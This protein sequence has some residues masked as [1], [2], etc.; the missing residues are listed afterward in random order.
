[1]SDEFSRTQWATL[2]E[3]DWSIIATYHLKMSTNGFHDYP[4]KLMDFT[5]ISQQSSS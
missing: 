3:R 5:C 1:M 2:D 4:K